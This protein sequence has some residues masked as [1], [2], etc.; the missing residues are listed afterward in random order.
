MILPTRIII[1]SH[2]PGEWETAPSLGVELVSP[3]RK[4]EGKAESREPNAATRRASDYTC[5]APSAAQVQVWVTT[6]KG[7]DEASSHLHLRAVQVCRPCPTAEWQAQTGTVSGHAA[8][9]IH[10]I[11]PNETRPRSEAPPYGHG[12]WTHGTD[13]L[14]QYFVTTDRHTMPIIAFRPF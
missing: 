10:G 2:L 13:M 9:R 8:M 11:H 12:K 3:R 7:A 1:N 14:C 6:S 5:T 4:R